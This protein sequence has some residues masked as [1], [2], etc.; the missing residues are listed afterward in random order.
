MKKRKELVQGALKTV[1]RH[2]WMLVLVCLIGT[3][4]GIE[5]EENLDIAGLRFGMEQELSLI[6]I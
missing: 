3:V 1:R 2:Y 5:N 4:L 6:H